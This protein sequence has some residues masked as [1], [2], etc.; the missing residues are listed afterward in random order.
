[1]IKKPQGTSNS[2]S[3]ASGLRRVHA[4][5]LARESLCFPAE[6]VKGTSS[7]DRGRQCLEQ[8]LGTGQLFNGLS[9][10]ESPA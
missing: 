8:H 7:E 6:A 1:M 3:F 4:A 5:T 2:H 10:D 9:P